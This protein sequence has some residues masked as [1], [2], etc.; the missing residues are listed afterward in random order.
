MSD[1]RESSL[2]RRPHT[3]TIQCLWGHDTGTDYSYFGIISYDHWHCQCSS[4]RH[5]SF[6]L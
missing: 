2:Y 4:F 1:I 5:F 3:G 6:R